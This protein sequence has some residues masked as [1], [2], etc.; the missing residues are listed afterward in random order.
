M[1]GYVWWGRVSFSVTNCNPKEPWRPDAWG[2]CCFFAG[3]MHCR[4]GRDPQWT[5]SSGRLSKGFWAPAAV[6]P[7][8]KNHW[9][10][11][12]LLECEPFC[13]RCPTKPELEVLWRAFNHE[14]KALVSGCL[15]SQKFVDC[16]LKLEHGNNCTL[17]DPSHNR[18]GS[19]SCFQGLALRPNMDLSTGGDVLETLVS[20]SRILW[21]AIRRLGMECV[22]ILFL[23]NVLGLCL[24]VYMPITQ[25]LWQTYYPHVVIHL[26]HKSTH[27]HIYMCIV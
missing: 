14:A 7:R 8:S 10:I 2:S 5:N 18:Q 9:C 22:F 21:S 3:S 16:C 12:V 4:F 11:S 24:D 6:T 17:L 20:Q 1:F 19:F 27:T 23:D 25:W 26:K 15:W 13:Y